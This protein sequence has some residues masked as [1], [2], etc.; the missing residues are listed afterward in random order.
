MQDLGVKTEDVQVRTALSK[1]SV[2]VIQEWV[3]DER[4]ISKDTCMIWLKSGES[5]LINRSYDFIV[6]W[7]Y[8]RPLSD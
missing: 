4:E 8:G 6:K 5:L 2:D 1:H 7:K 3:D